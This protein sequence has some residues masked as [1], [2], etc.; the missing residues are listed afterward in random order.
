MK[1]TRNYDVYIL[2]DVSGS[3]GAHVD[4][5]EC[6]QTVFGLYQNNA[7]WMLAARFTVAIAELLGRVRG[8]RIGI[9]VHDHAYMPLKEFGDKLT[10]E[11]KCFIM[12]QIGA[13]G[14]TDADHAYDEIAKKFA[15]STAE[16]KLLIHL[17]DG[18]F[19]SA[20]HKQIKTLERAGVYVAI[21]TVGIDAKWARQFVP[22]DQADEIN[23]ETIGTVLNRH[24]SRMIAA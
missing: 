4:G 9:G 16:K 14:G 23:D 22:E 11:R 17:T 6:D 1:D 15:A 13:F 10:S 19:S 12:N 3:M 24:F 7:R 21:L 8:V 18:A 20:V 2:N 5:V